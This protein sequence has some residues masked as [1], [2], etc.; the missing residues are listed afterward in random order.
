MDLPLAYLLLPTRMEAP[1]RRGLGSRPL[2][3]TFSSP[4][5]P[6]FKSQLSSSFLKS[7]LVS[8]IRHLASLGRNYK[9]FILLPVLQDEVASRCWMKAW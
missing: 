9:R 8:P 2:T 4:S 6:M 3:L 5:T 7:R 1:E